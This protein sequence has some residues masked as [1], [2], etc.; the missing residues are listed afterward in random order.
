MCLHRCART[1]HR[2]PTITFWT[3]T[4][5]AKILNLSFVS[6]YQVI[7]SNYAMSE[8]SI[9]A[10]SDNT[11]C[12]KC[13]YARLSGWATCSY[14]QRAKNELQDLQKSFPEKY[15][16]VLHESA[17]RDEFRTMMY[18]NFLDRPCETFCLASVDKKGR[19]RGG[20]GACGPFDFFLQ[21]LY[22]KC[23]KLS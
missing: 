14:Y 20:R 2:V 6:I 19:R 13:M 15:E 12:D 8:I 7:K 22:E 21:K 10:T 1:D 23:R 11:F 5:L 16:V 4:Q 9:D 18:I 17:T 3:W